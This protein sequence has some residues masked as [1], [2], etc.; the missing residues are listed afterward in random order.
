LSAARRLRRGGGP[1]QLTSQARRRQ[2]TQ[3]KSDPIDAV[4]I[5]RITR[6]EP[7][8]PRIRPDGKLE[9]LRVLV[10]HRRELRAE[11]NRMANRSMR[12]WSSFTPATSSGS[13]G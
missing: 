12:T 11:R 13:V 3:A 2:R 10:R 7:D 9:D 5:A 6:R 8:L 1:P 4:L